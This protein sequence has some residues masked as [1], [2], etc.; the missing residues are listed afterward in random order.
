MPLNGNSSEPRRWWVTA[1]VILAAVVLLA[2]FVF[3]RD[4]SVPVRTAEVEQGKIRSIISTNGKIE[5]VSNFEAHAPLPINVLHVYVKEGAAVK[6]G[7]LLVA[8]DDADARTLAAHTQSQLKTSQSDLAT[9]EHG[10]SQEEVLNLDVQR[11]KARTERDS[12]Q[13]NLDA[14]KK[15]QQQGAASMGEVRE[16]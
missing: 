8:L 15:L 3:R 7:Q 13:R 14:L 4:D 9:I 16:A 10:G 1:I 2:A 5:P 12:A 6:K 11:V